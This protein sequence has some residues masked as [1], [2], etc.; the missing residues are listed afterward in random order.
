M[1]EYFNNE[2]FSDIKGI[3][4][5]ENGQK[6][7][8]LHKIIL[9]MSCEYFKRF[10][11]FSGNN[12]NEFKINTSFNVAKLFFEMCYKNPKISGDI[13]ELVQ[14]RIKDISLKEMLEFTE[15]CRIYQPY[16]FNITAHFLSKNEYIKK[17]ITEIMSCIPD[18]ENLSYQYKEYIVN[19][20]INDMLADKESIYHVYNYAK[21]IILTTPGIFDVFLKHIMINY[22]NPDY[23]YIINDLENSI[24]LN[25]LSNLGDII[26]IDHNIINNDIIFNTYINWCCEQSSSINLTS[27]LNISSKFPK[28]YNKIIVSLASNESV[29]KK[30]AGDIIIYQII[31]NSI[32]SINYVLPAETLET[33]TR[34]NIKDNDITILYNRVGWCLLNEDNSTLLGDYYNIIRILLEYLFTSNAPFYDIYKYTDLIN[35]I[36]MNYTTIFS[37]PICLE[38]LINYIQKFYNNSSIVEYI[39][40]QLLTSTRYSLKYNLDSDG[41]V[42]FNKIALNLSKNEK[43]IEYLPNIIICNRYQDDLIIDNMILKTYILSNQ[44]I[45]NFKIIRSLLSKKTLNNIHHKLLIISFNTRV[46][47]KNHNLLIKITTYEKIKTLMLNIQKDISKNNLLIIQHYQKYQQEISDNDVL[48][49]DSTKLEQV[50]S[51]LLSESLDNNF[52][53]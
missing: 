20:I 29:Y 4:E 12:T 15:L 24:T 40:Q 11:S 14:N 23:N 28:K 32:N 6:E 41:N 8:Y 18:P 26:Y 30:I 42:I 43:F 3:Y 45:S 1:S 37:S 2:P 44:D 27:F 53:S 9:A 46:P 50:L 47:I 5:D 49:F 16:T 51:E 21:V 39:R 31:L 7:I 34:M 13:Q 35:G 25:Q 33:I 19:L 52:D 17:D 36:I 38:I 48:K 22:N 10:F